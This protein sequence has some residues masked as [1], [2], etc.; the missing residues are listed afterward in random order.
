MNSVSVD[1]HTR[2]IKWVD[3]KPTLE[4]IPILTKDSLK[5]LPELALSL[6]YERTP[7][8]KELDHH[9][10][11]DGMSKGEVMFHKLA[12]QAAEGDL[13]AIKE[14]LDRILGKPKQEVES[15]RLS[16]TYTDYLDELRRQEEE[17]L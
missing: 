5:K 1:Y 16:L 3:G 14:M 12:S 4:M 2:A 6:P 11:Y 10:E 15:K 17:E 7:L 9:P 13:P 8:E